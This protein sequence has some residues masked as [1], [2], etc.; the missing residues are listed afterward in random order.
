M[1]ECPI[2]HDSGTGAILH[3]LC[4]LQRKVRA[5]TAQMQNLDIL[6][7]PDPALQKNGVP[8]HHQRTRSLRVVCEIQIAVHSLKLEI[9][10]SCHVQFPIRLDYAALV[11]AS[12]L[13][14]SSGPVQ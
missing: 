12:M 2:C 14:A 13:S 8:D 3:R 5:R 9:D 6:D 7:S 4:L 10:Y 11:L 1:V